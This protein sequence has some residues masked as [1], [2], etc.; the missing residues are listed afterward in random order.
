MNQIIEIDKDKSTHLMLS[1]SQNSQKPLEPLIELYKGKLF[2]CLIKMF[3]NDCINHFG[4][5]IFSIKKSFSRTLTNLL[6]SWM[7]S[8]Y[9]DYDFSSDYFFPTNYQNTQHLEDTL[10]DL[11]KYDPQITNINIKINKTMTNLKNNYKI[12]MQNNSNFNLRNNN[13]QSKLSNYNNII[14]ILLIRFFG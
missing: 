2:S 12:Q 6:S 8:L 3:T 7:F 5:Q 11:C 10:R 13:N 14:V 9:V 4:T 1:S